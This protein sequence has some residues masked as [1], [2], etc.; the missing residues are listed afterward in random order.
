M[1]EISDLVG[2]PPA[3]VAAMPEDA[4][5]LVGVGWVADVFGIRTGTVI[6]AIKVGKLPYVAIPGSNGSIAAYAV[7]PKDAARLWGSRLLK[8]TT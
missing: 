3:I 2:L 1:P 4:P 5:E 7:R 8:K 6:H